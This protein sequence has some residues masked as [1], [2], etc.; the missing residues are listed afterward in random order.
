MKDPIKTIHDSTNIAL[1]H[2]MALGFALP[3]IYPLRTIVRVPEIDKDGKVADESLQNEIKKGLESLGST[4]WQ[5]PVTLK[6]GA[7]EFML[8]IDPVIAINGNNKIIR[9]Y[10]NKSQ[11]RGSIKERWNQDDYEITI[12]GIITSD[13]NYSIYDYLTRLRTFC[14]ARESIGI[15]CDLLN[16]VFDIHYIAIDSYDFPFTRGADNQQFTIKAFSDDNYLLLTD[17]V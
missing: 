6:M 2:Q 15:V 10:V 7:D 3:P 12:G 16:N 5:V 14:E 4:L 13:E 9:R 8:P 11:V 17:N 1:S